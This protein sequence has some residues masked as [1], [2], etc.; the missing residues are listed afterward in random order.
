ME[1][2]AVVNQRFE[3][4]TPYG[5][6]DFAGLRLAPSHEQI[7]VEFDDGSVLEC[8]PK[9]KIQL[10]TGSFTEATDLC[11]DDLTTTALAV[12]RITKT[13]HHSPVDYYDA[14][15][16]KKSN[17]YFTNRVVSHNCEFIGSSNTLINPDVLQKMQYLH[18]IHKNNNINVFVEPERGHRY[19]ITVDTSRG[20]GLDYS[21]FIVVDITSFP[22]QVVATYRDQSI[23]PVLYPNYIDHAARMYNNA[24]IL[25]ET[26]DVGGQIADLLNFELENEGLL[27]VTQTGKKG[28]TLG[29]GFGKASRFGVKTTVQVRRI[30]CMA[31]K[32]LVEAFALHCNDINIIDELTTFVLDGDR[33][34]AET[35]RHDDLV[36]CLVLFSWMTTQKYFKELAESDVRQKFLD[37]NTARLEEDMLPFGFIDDGRDFEMELDNIAAIPQLTGDRF[38]L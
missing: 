6:S 9:H 33:Y 38:L 19:A 14:I 7:R 2:S 34:E 36:M 24:Y 30:G 8:T 21:A 15:E 31:L 5:W 12:T 17:R 20:M 18:P 11:I 16:V 4:L 27:M 13:K 23:P 26:N 32:S 28:Q 1:S 10:H 37:D 22:Y 3:I 25:V 29:G 35:G